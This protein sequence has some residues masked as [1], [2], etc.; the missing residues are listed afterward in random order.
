MSFLLSDVSYEAARGQ[1]MHILGHLK[2]LAKS[3]G[4]FPNTNS[5]LA[6][7]FRA[8]LFIDLGKAMLIKV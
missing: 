3:Y 4:A 7:A 6:W 1:V 8:I 2:P 5:S